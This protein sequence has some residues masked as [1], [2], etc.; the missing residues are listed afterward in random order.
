M[1]RFAPLNQGKLDFDEVFLKINGRHHYLWRAV[2]QAGD[3]LDIPVQ[4]RMDKKTTNKFFRKLLKGL[5][6]VPRAIFTVKLTN[7]SAA[8]VE[9]MPSE[10]HLQQKYQNNR[11]ENSLQPM[12]LREKVMRRSK[13]AGHAERYLSAFGLI[14][15]HFHVGR[16]LY[17]AKGY[18][19]VMKSRFAIWKNVIGISLVA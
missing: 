19:T 9:V 5:W 11:A 6:H 17:S 8:I 13:S 14:S 7:Y 4:S 2:D 15:S 3:V 10:E 1:L 16:H 18:R 12:R